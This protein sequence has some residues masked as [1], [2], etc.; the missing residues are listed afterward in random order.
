MQPGGYFE[1]PV[2][3]CE[4]MNLF[5]VIDYHAKPTAG[6]WV[7]TKRLNN[8]EELVIEPF[9]GQPFIGVVKV[10]ELYRLAQQERGETGS[11]LPYPG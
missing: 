10:L 9:Y 2:Y 11:A 7:V 8:N 3:Y 5:H 6:S 1:Q 4:T